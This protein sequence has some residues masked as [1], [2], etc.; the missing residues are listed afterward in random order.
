[1]GF[2]TKCHERL[3]FVILS[4]LVGALKM[5]D[6]NTSFDASYTDRKNPFESALL[7]M[8]HDDLVCLL[9]LLKKGDKIFRSFSFPLA[10]SN[11][12]NNN[13]NQRS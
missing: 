9:R 1:M 6:R 11:E 5:T 13:N 7:K 3:N 10:Q 2:L 4:I 12:N 8:K